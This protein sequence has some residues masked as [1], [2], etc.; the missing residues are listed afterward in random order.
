MSERP[1]TDPD[2]SPPSFRRL[3]ELFE[4]LQEMP[5]ADREAEIERSAAGAP[6][7]AEELRALLGHAERTDSPL[8]NAALLFEEWL[9]PPPPEIPGFRIDSRIGRGGSATVYLAQQ[10]HADFT[11]NVAVKVVDRVVDATSL[12]RVREE[13]RILARLEHPGIARLYD[14]GV[15]PP[16]QP[17][18]VMEHVEGESILEHCRSR[19]LP[20]RER[21]EL[22]LS[23]LDAVAYAHGQGV[24]HRD[25]KP[26]N[27]LVSARGEAKLLDFGIAK[28]IANPDDAGETQTLHGPMTPAY[29]SPEQV[30]GGRITPAS[31]VYSLGVVLYELV[32][33]TSP[34]RIREADPEPPSNAFARTAGATAGWRRALSG[35]LDAVIL[36]A[37]RKEP[38][39]RYASV[40]ELAQE[41][42]RFLAGGPVLA[43]SEIGYR[44]RSFARHQRARAVVLGIMVALVLVAV[45]SRRSGQSGNSIPDPA[46]FPWQWVSL[47]DPDLERIY[48]RGLERRAAGQVTAAA[49]DFREVLVARPEEALVG[50][51]L[52]DS[53]SVSGRADDAAVAADAANRA[54]RHAPKL[55]REARLLVE[56]IALRESGK[57]SEA[58]ERLRSLTLLDPNNLEVALLLGGSLTESGG[59]LETLEIAQ[60]LSALPQS[61][62]SAIRIEHLHI[63]ALDR[64]GRQKEV[65]ALAGPAAARAMSQSLSAWAARF[66]GRE[67]HAWDQLGE[68]ARAKEIIPRLAEQARLSGE[69]RLVALSH[70]LSCFVAIREAR[71]DDVERECGMSLAIDRRLGN[72]RNASATINALGA[73]RRRRGHLEE[74]RAAF[75]EAWQISQKRGDR[76]VGARYRSNLANT[77][78][79]LGRYEDA[80]QG[81]REAVAMRRADGDQ[82]SGALAL[83]GLANALTNRGRLRD[84]EPLLMEAERSLRGAKGRELPLVLLALAELRAALGERPRAM[85]LLDEAIRLHESGGEPDNVAYVSAVRAR[86]ETGRR[87]CEV[88]SRSAGKLREV[89]DRRL[90]E[91]LAW[92]TG[93]WARALDVGRAEQALA[94]GDAAAATSSAPAPR[95]DLALASAELALARRQPADALRI[96]EAAA[97]QCRAIDH[98]AKLLQVRLLSA[99]AEAALGASPERLRTLLE[100]LRDDARTQRFEAI[101]AQASALHLRSAAPR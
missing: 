66:L 71:H 2:P 20:L 3:R 21:L 23:V 61:E 97:A 76:A 35:D 29:A 83:R 65:A 6:A 7:L 62:E 75:L 19:R 59:A 100:T 78:L 95:I 93:C 47:D 31:D 22:C 54:L 39:A 89:G 99:R 26:A 72:L 9:E 10:Q 80:E 37:L 25:L 28:L 91:V 48:A 60:R 50:A 1:V 90:A 5:V 12:R 58:V 73:S 55:R 45:V 52:S 49:A 18:L 88:L 86:L 36:K 98:V 53:L 24:V 30:A 17:Y 69:P 64:L 56:A 81:F 67:G 32:A 57:Q 87:A 85:A 94:L 11:R 33:E 42:R 82:R 15:T 68:S 16:G 46:L 40:S 13:Q 70:G 101:A 63:T 4:R 34:D 14:S 74:A 44:L 51:V 77:D 38:E 8:D 96:L 84:A 41:L 79:D 43:R 27:I 92:E